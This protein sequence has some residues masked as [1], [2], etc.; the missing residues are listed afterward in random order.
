MAEDIPIEDEIAAPQ[1]WG[2]FDRTSDKEVW[3]G[4]SPVLTGDM[5]YMGGNQFCIFDDPSGP[6]ITGDIH[7]LE[8]VP[9]KITILKTIKSYDGNIDPRGIS[10]DGSFFHV[11]YKNFDIDPPDYTYEQLDL[12]GSVVREIRSIKFPGE[13]EGMCHFQDNTGEYFAIL[14]RGQQF[15]LGDTLL[16]LDRNFNL[17]DSFIMNDV[18]LGTAFGIIHDGMNF[19]IAHHGTQFVRPGLKIIDSISEKTVWS[20][21]GSLDYNGMTYDGLQIYY[22]FGSLQITTGDPEEP[23]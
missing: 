19:I 12:N 10:Y 4:S 20:F 3:V 17:V 16:I 5:D 22:N 11:V 13:L 9:K 7:I 21:S 8:I 1:R 14:H 23:I 18:P 15:E 2:C 6:V